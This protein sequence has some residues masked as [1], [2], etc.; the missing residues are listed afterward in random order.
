MLK[1]NKSSYFNNETLSY[2]N[3]N[4]A[5]EQSTKILYMSDEDDEKDVEL[6][7]KVNESKK[8][9]ILKIRTFKD[10]KSHFNNHHIIFIYL[11]NSLYFSAVL[12]YIN[13]NKHN[14]KILAAMSKEHGPI[15]DAI[16]N[17]VN[18]FLFLPITDE[19]ATNLLIKFEEFDRDINLLYKVYKIKSLD[20]VSI[21]LKER[22]DFYSKNINQEFNKLFIFFLKVLENI[23]N[24][25][26]LSNYYLFKDD[27]YNYFVSLTSLSLYDRTKYIESFALKMLYLT[28]YDRIENTILSP[29]IDEVIVEFKEIYGKEQWVDNFIDKIK[30]LF[31]LEIKF[32]GI[33]LKIFIQNAHKR[34]ERDLYSNSLHFLMSSSADKLNNYANEISID[35]GLFKKP[36][37]MLQNTIPKDQTKINKLI[38]ILENKKPLENFEK[39]LNKQSKIFTKFK[40]EITLDSSVEDL[41]FILEFAFINGMKVKNNKI[42]IN[43]NK[44]N[45]EN[46]ETTNIILND[47]VII[48]TIY[49]IIENAIQAKCNHIEFTLSEKNEFIYLD[50]SNDGEII[51]EDI[52]TK[53]FK[54]FFTTKNDSFEKKDLEVS[55]S[56]LGLFI[57]EKWLKTID[58]RYDIYYDNDKKCFV[59]KIPIIYL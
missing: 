26:S 30:I 2:I 42:S 41:I 27:L 20:S 35:L 24:N 36:L 1:D 11:K 17:K 55:H 22:K 43:L 57:V 38:K 58:D 18:D 29:L 8:F 25:S 52:Q 5:L 53:L 48:S 16:E 59:I 9:E 7:K 33:T 10:F 14:Q 40:D 13:N 31:E 51:T 12:N 37:D 19:F 34:K 56:G 28:N 54:N 23:L 39:F 3:D 21:I 44:N 49:A 47:N 4:I 32:I 45:L 46:T 50:I 6:F 15:A